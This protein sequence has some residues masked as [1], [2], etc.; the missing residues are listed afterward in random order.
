VEPGLPAAYASAGLSFSGA[1]ILPTDF[2]RPYRSLS[3]ITY[4]FFDA[5]SSFN[6]LQV[7]L[8]R[9]F[10]RGVTFGVAYTLSRT[11]TTVSDDGTF[12][13]VKD[14]AHYDYGN[15]T[16][17][18]PH[19]FVGNFVWDLP[20]GSKLL[21]GRSAARMIFDNWTVSGAT[22]IASGNPTELTLSIAGQDAGNRLLGAPPAATCRASSRASN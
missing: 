19:Y 2:L 3:D 20:K 12:T 6:S 15:A 13:N 11:M 21:G 7:N 18:R 16:F 17:D 4:Y 5:E 8:Q 9:R 1:N 22:T 10:A 14:A